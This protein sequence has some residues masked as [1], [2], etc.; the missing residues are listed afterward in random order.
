[1]TRGQSSNPNWITERSNRVTSSNFGKICKLRATTS[2]ANTVK[3]LLYSTFTGSAATHYGNEYE[4]VARDEF[5]K[6]TGLTV[7]ESGLVVDKCHPFLGASPDGIILNEDAVLEI[8]CPFFAKDLTPG[9][10]RLVIISLKGVTL[11]CIRT[12][13]DERRCPILFLECCYVTRENDFYPKTEAYLFLF[14]NGP[15]LP[16]NV[17]VIAAGNLNAKRSLGLLTH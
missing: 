5:S 4:T 17:P 6:V 3:S 1:M 16:P 11:S 7:K 15:I 12:T 8:K 2:C 13:T 14:E 9:S 10:R